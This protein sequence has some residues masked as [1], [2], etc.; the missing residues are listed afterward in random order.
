MDLPDTNYTD[1]IPFEDITE[2]DVIGWIETKLASQID[3]YQGFTL[4]KIRAEMQPQ[5]VDVDLP[6]IANP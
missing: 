5:P 2:N 6:W 1:F 4:N 3:F